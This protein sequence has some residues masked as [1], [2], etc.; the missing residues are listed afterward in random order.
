MKDAW[1][2]LNETQRKKFS[3]K[4]D[5]LK[6]KYIEQFEVFLKTLSKDEIK[7]YKK[8][9]KELEERQAAKEKSKNKDTLEGNSDTKT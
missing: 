3:D 7:A 5:K 1:R 9:R 4:V 8:H 6:T 2:R